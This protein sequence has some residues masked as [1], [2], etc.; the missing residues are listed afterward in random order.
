[1]LVRLF[2]GGY[3]IHGGVVKAL[4]PAVFLKVVRLYDMLPE[5][6]AVLLNGTAIV[7]PWVEIV[8]GVALVVGLFIRGAGVL[9]AAMLC[10]FTPAI[11][12]RALAVTAEEGIS[13]FQVE[14]DCGCGTGNEII[15]LK[16]CKNTGLLLLAI[17]AIVSRSRRFCLT[18]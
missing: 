4:D 15:W 2:L 8:C 16:L 1:V 12:L 5:T 17:F 13:F 10:V 3:F 11:F 9:I 18:S 6:P 14:F 7:L